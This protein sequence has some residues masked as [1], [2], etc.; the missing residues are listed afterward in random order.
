VKKVLLM[1]DQRAGWSVE[2]MVVEMVAKK[3]Q[4]SAGKLG[5]TLV[6]MLVDSMGHR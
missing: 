1:V 6:E 4:K 3:A 5:K 2:T